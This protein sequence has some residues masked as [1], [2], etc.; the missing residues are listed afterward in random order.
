MCYYRFRLQNYTDGA[1]GFRQYVPYVN[2]SEV[3]LNAT[4]RITARSLCSLLRG[5]M[6]TK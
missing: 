3:L 6:P 5:S 4:F 2:Q 1:N